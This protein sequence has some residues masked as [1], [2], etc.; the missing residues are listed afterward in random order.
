MKGRTGREEIQRAKKVDKIS[1]SWHV[2]LAV[3]ENNIH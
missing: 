1:V 3:S 2:T